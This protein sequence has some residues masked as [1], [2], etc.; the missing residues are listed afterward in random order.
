MRSHHTEQILLL[1]AVK[2]LVFLAPSLEASTP[3]DATQLASKT[4]SLPSGIADVAGSGSEAEE[5]A[6]AAAA[7]PL[8]AALPGQAAATGHDSEEEDDDDHEVRLIE[9]CCIG[10]VAWCSHQSLQ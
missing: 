7:A 5:E 10:T 2:C 1:Q 4:Q 8:A 3:S 9:L 6:A